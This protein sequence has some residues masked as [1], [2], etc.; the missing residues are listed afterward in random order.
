MTGLE[1]VIWWTEYVIRN[2]GAV[3]LRNP[4]ADVS[5]AEILMLDV[6]AFLLSILVFI[7]FLV[8]C[9]CQYFFCLFLTH[10]KTKQK[11]E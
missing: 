1:K 8:Y 2:Q 5:W 6:I 11:L 7:F 9:G 4:R 3:H 10:Q